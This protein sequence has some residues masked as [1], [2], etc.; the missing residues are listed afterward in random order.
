MDHCKPGGGIRCFPVFEAERHNDPDDMRQAAVN[1][2]VC[3]AR[4]RKLSR[5]EMNYN[6]M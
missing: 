1:V 6:C 5:G 2:R 4:S 3:C